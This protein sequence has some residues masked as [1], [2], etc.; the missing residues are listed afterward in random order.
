MCLSEVYEHPVPTATTN[1]IATFSNTVERS[2]AIY[3]PSLRSYVSYKFTRSHALHPTSLS[4]SPFL[5]YISSLPTVSVRSDKRSTQTH[6]QVSRIPGRAQANTPDRRDYEVGLR[7]ERAHQLPS[8]NKRRKKCGKNLLSLRQ[9]YTASSTSSSG[10]LLLGALSLSL[11]IRLPFVPASSL[12]RPPCIF[13]PFALCSSSSSSSFDHRRCYQTTTCTGARPTSFLRSSFSVLLSRSPS[14]PRTGLTRPLR[15]RTTFPSR[16][17]ILTPLSITAPSLPLFFFSDTRG[18]A[19]SGCS[20]LSV[21][22]FYRFPQ[23]RIVIIAPA[24]VP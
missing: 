8:Y 11:S 21:T 2:A 3:L 9:V 23:R 7:G 14:V 24:I 19:S 16:S 15:A 1:T 22:F 4:F 20:R 10:R 13:L 18:G 12:P 6:A 17:L 5:G